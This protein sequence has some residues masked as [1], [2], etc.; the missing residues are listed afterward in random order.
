MGTVNYTHIG[1][2]PKRTLLSA[3]RRPFYMLACSA[4]AAAA[5]A[6]SVSL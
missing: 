2:K 1:L 5:A 3:L 4:A 6:R